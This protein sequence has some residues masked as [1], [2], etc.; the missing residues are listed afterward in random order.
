MQQKKIKKNSGKKAA[1]EK[2]GGSSVESG[3]L[4]GEDG[5]W[6]RSERVGEQG[7]GLGG[8]AAVARDGRRIRGDRRQ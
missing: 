8:G 7:W 5:G 1:T 2:R 4:E 6:G 3:Q